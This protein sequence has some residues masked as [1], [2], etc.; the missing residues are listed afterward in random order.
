MLIPDATVLVVERVIGD[1][2]AQTVGMVWNA[3]VRDPA[4]NGST[5]MPCIS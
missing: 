1:A 5:T 2:G 3:S 4:E